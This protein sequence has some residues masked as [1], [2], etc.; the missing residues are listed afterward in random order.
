MWALVLNRDSPTIAGRRSERQYGASSPAN[1]GAKHTPPGSV[2]AEAG[3]AGLTLG[4]VG[5]RVS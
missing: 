5:T 1:A 4:R 2:Q 3:A